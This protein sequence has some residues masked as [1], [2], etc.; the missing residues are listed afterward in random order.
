MSL[1][2]ALFAEWSSA[3]YEN[4]ALFHFCAGSRIRLSIEGCEQVPSDYLRFPH[5]KIQSFHMVI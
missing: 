1:E 5:Y 4:C 2:V 3:R